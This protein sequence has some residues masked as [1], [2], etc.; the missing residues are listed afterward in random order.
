[1]EQKFGLS[2]LTKY[3]IKLM[4]SLKAFASM[5]FKLLGNV[6]EVKPMH[7]EKAPEAIFVVPSGI[8]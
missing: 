8:T 7:L 5:L 2:S 4:Q 3:S 6:I 1:M